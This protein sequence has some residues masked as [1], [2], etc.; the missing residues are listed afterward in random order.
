MMQ[1][2]TIMRAS[3]SSQQGEHNVHPRPPRALPLRGLLCGQ[4]LHPCCRHW[5]RQPCRQYLHLRLC[6]SLEQKGKLFWFWF[7]PNI[8][9]PGSEERRSVGE[10]D[11]ALERRWIHVSSK[12]LLPLHATSCILQLP[13]GTMDSCKFKI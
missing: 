11:Q 7:Q 9:S 8:L 13:V 6:D 5:C 4:P 3:Y 2:M 12:P 1:K 10:E